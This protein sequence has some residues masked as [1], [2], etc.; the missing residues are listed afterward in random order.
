[1]GTRLGLELY[2]RSY[3]VGAS[4]ITNVV[5][6]CSSLVKV[7]YQIPQL[8]HELVGNS[9]GLYPRLDGSRG[10]TQGFLRGLQKRR[11]LMRQERQRKYNVIYS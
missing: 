5:V 3:T 6:P 8:Y 1:M 2:V 4:I 11:V 9:S 10:Y 7:L